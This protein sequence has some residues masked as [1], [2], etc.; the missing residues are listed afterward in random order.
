[1]HSA[2]SQ[3]FF[4]FLLSKDHVNPK[5]L[6]HTIALG[7]D[8]LPVSITADEKCCFKIQVADQTFSDNTKELPVAKFSE[9]VDF[10]NLK[11]HGA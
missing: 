1:M 6:K 3:D 11:L 7:A 8:N 4:T 2:L 5:V 9:Q 10:T